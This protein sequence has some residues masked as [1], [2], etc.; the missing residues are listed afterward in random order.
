MDASGTTSCCWTFRGSQPCT[1]CGVP[2]IPAGICLEYS[3]AVN[4]SACSLMSA[5]PNTWTTEP[6]QAGAGFGHEMSLGTHVKCR[7]TAVGAPEAGAEGGRCVFLSRTQD[8][9]AM[10]SP[11]PHPPE[12]DE[13]LRGCELYVQTHGVQQVLKDCV[14]HLCLS[15]PERPMK[16]LREHFAKLEKVSGDAPLP[17]LPR[18]GPCPLPTRRPSVLWLPPGHRAPPPALGFRS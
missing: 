16:F 1:K 14:V 12:E 2:S 15:K 3:L 10:A 5:G 13:S 8:A 6:R 4:N 9:G 7:F 11:P 17:A 18:S